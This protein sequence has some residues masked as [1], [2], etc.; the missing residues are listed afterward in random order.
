MWLHRASTGG[1]FGAALSTGRVCF[2][3]TTICSSPP[4][5]ADMNLLYHKIV[6]GVYYDSIKILIV[7]YYDIS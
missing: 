2:T 4:R 6:L 1:G 5:G 3:A 7:I